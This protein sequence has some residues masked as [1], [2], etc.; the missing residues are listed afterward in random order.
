MRHSPEIAD[1]ES[2]RR[3]KT[4]VDTREAPEDRN[5][6]IVLQGSAP[7][8]T[9]SCKARTLGNS[10][11]W[12]TRGDPMS[13]LTM[14]IRDGFRRANRLDRRSELAMAYRAGLLRNAIT[15]AR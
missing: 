10:P 12:G 3:V 6:R 4:R 11:P 1:D 7:G 9:P 14:L 5:R 15:S 8:M 2:R 13:T